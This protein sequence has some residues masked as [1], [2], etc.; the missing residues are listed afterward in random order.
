MNIFLK[1]VKKKQ[2]KEFWY[3][4][5]VYI[6]P[7]TLLS[8]VSSSKSVPLMAHVKEPAGSEHS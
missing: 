3:V 2:K 6:S 7:C 1:K 8:A 4:K 5:I